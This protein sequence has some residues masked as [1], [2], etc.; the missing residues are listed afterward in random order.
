MEMNLT[1]RIGGDQ[2]QGGGSRA[3][4][5]KINDASAVLSLVFDKKT[6]EYEHHEIYEKEYILQNKKGKK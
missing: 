2:Y 5:L 1:Y 4:Y 3:I 6:G